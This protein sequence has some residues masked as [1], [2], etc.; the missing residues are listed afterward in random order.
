MDIIVTT[1]IWFNIV[2]ETDL[3]IRPGCWIN[4]LSILNKQTKITLG[5]QI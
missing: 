4:P 3:Q 1:R 2:Q 5:E